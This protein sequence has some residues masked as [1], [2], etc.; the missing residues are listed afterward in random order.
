MT[1]PI[2]IQIDNTEYIRKDAQTPPP[3][4]DYVIVR[5]DRAGVFAGHLVEHDRE[6]RHVV[7][8]DV[9]RLWSWIGCSL[10]EVAE[11]GAIEPDNCKY[12]V[13][14]ATQT[15]ATVIE[16]IPATESAMAS[17]KGVDSWTRQ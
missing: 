4:Q 6:T 7:L 5:S 8:K 2:T 13:P 12:S 15:I 17:I 14:V 11:K 9:R 10:S 3:S 16:V 1:A